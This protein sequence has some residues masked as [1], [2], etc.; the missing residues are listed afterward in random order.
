MSKLHNIIRDIASADSKRWRE[1]K[2]RRGE[3][4][5]QWGK[6]PHMGPDLVVAGDAATD[7]SDRSLVMYAFISPQMEDGFE[8]PSLAEELH[9]RGYDLRTLRFSIRKTETAA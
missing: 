9:S 1:P 5:L 8:E 3:I 2:P 7:R 6:I 4:K